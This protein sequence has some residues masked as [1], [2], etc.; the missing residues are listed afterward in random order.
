[1]DQGLGQAIPLQQTGTSQLHDVPNAEDS[2]GL[3]CPPRKHWLQCTLEDNFLKPKTRRGQILC[4]LFWLLAIAA[5]CVLFWQVLPRFVDHVVK[6]TIKYIERHFTKVQVAGIALAAM[7]VFPVVFISSTPIM[8]LVSAVLGFWWG[9]LVTTIG[10]A[11]GML[12]SFLVG[13]QIFRD[14]LHGWVAGNPKAEAMLLAISEAGTFKVIVLMRQVVPYTWLNYAAS[15]PPEIT[16]PWYMLASVI[17][18]VPHNA[19]DVY[20]GGNVTGL[21]DLLAGKP[22]NTATIVTYTLGFTAA[23]L[24]AGLAYFYAKRA[25]RKIEQQAQQQDA[26]TPRPLLQS[27]AGNARRKAVNDEAALD[28]CNSDETGQPM[29]LQQH[30]S[31]LESPITSDGHSPSQRRLLHPGREVTAEIESSPV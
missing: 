18:Q 1:M 8:L 19:V 25:L 10:T 13:K 24:V 31:G 9:F 14:R 15:A 28:A 23:T 11:I 2:Q 26:N 6:P 21:G 20:L 27:S 3:H 4:C 22:A 17:G 12:L 16:L 5:G 29:L 7:S 30:R